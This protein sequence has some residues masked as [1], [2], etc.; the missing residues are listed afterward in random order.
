M[1][2]AQAAQ[3]DID[4]LV[5]IPD[6]DFRAVVLGDIDGTASL[7]HRHALRARMVLTR[8]RKHLHQLTTDT[9]QQLAARKHEHGI[10]GWRSRAE[11]HRFALRSRAVECQRLRAEAQAASVARGDFALRDAEA[12]KASGASAKELRA[13][14][15]EVALD[16]LIAAHRTEFA[17][18]VAEACDALGVSVPDSIARD[19]AQEGAPS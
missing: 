19:L 10:D 12:A 15:G 14:A 2:A 1:D 17:R 18:H 7:P 11:R 3:A 6:S 13:R 9:E 4:W 16:R 5:A 8:W